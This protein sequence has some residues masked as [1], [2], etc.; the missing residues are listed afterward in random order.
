[1]E[2]KKLQE[3]V[4]L[5]EKYLSFLLGKIHHNIAKGFKLQG[6][7]IPVSDSNNGAMYYVA[8]LIR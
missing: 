4:V 5:E 8:T 3:V 7:V 6:A 1:M 2:D